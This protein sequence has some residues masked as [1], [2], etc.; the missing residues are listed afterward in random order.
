MLMAFIQRVWIIMFTIGRR[1][2]EHSSRSEST[3][4]TPCNSNPLKT[5]VVG[6][7]SYIYQG[8]TAG[9]QLCR[10]HKS[11]LPCRSAFLSMR[12]FISQPFLVCWATT[13]TGRKDCPSRCLCSCT[14]QSSYSLGQMQNLVCPVKPN[15][16]VTFLFLSVTLPWKN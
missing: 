12:P 10:Q 13:L 16:N 11:A 15:L 1:R 6:C 7:V 2:S 5:Q 14:P 8:S 4:C 9:V 3:C